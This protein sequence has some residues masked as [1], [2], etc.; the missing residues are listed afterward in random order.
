M[1]MKTKNNRLTTEDRSQHEHLLIGVNSFTKNRRM[2]RKKYI[3]NITENQ[4]V[5][6]RQQQVSLWTNSEQ[7]YFAFRLY[8]ELC[9]YQKSTELY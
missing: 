7:V 9:M 2:I 5:S 8:M 6:E 3:N 1:N 4:K